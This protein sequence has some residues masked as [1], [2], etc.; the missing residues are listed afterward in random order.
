MKHGHNTGDGAGRIL[1]HAS[2]STHQHG[3]VSAKAGAWSSL[4]T[5]Q[6]R[7]DGFVYVE[8]ASPSKVAG[9]WLTT[10]PVAWVTGE[11]YVNADCAGQAGNSVSRP[12]PSWNRVHFD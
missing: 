5:Y 6:L 11:L 2:A 3:F 7:W 9:A 12:F 1:V 4:L 8:A 10:V